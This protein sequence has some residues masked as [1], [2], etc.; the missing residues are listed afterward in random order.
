MLQG[1]KNL[2]QSEFAKFYFDF[3]PFDYQKVAL[4]CNDR[5]ME[6]V[7]SRQT[8]KS[9]I[10]ALK[11]IFAAVMHDEW[12]VLVLAPTQRQSSRLFRKI[13]RF[14]T[15]SAIK[16]PELQITDLIERET[17][18]LIEFANGSEIIALPVGED[19]GNIRGYTANLVIIDEC[20]EIDSQEIWGAV[21]PMTL[22]TIGGQLLIGTLKGTHSEFYKIYKNP[23]LYKFRLFEANY[24]MN[25]KADRIQ[26]ELDKLRMPIAMW[27]Q[28]YMNI[29]MEEYDSFFPSN[30][31]NRV[32]ED[33]PQWEA[34]NPRRDYTY[35]LGVDIAGEGKDSTVYCVLVGTPSGKLLV[36]KFIETKGQTLPQ[37]EGNVRML[38]TL[39]GF[40]KIM[41]DCTG[42]RN[43]HEYLIKD[44]IPAEGF[45]FGL[46]SKEDVYQEL[47]RQMQGSTFAMYKCEDAIK[48]LIDMRYEH[49]KVGGEGRLRIYS[50]QSKD[51]SL[52][53]G[54]DYPTAL[55]LAVWAARIPTQ[56]LLFGSSRGIYNAYE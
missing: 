2:S 56:P 17:Q 4:D 8:G 44:N 52:P 50:G 42:G 39:W 23:K 45:V 35:Y 54:D 12:T 37:V 18:T 5:Y 38:H 28:E 46:K 21:N 11:A 20:G 49:A 47:K 31:V 10:T 7:W 43:I 51:H 1:I 36:G 6:F 30:L 9:T 13:K 48:Q 33:Y 24:L 27:N 29:P 3:E 22:M 15:S 34:P 14:I 41:I 32:V 25:P 40:K 19:G 53:G 16:H 26:I 55:V